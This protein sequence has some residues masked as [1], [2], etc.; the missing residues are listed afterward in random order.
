MYADDILNVKLHHVAVTPA[1]TW[2]FVALHLADQT[3]GWGEA[4]L[5]GTPALLT[6]PLVSARQALVGLRLPDLDAWRQAAPPVD[7]AQAAIAS[8]L[9]QATLDARG[10]QEGRSAAALLGGC[11]RASVPVYANINRRTVNRSPQGFIESAAHAIAAGYTTLKIAPFDGV[12]PATAS[13]PEGRALTEAGLQ[14]IAAT[15]AAA[16]DAV[17]VYVDCHWRFD[18]TAAGVVLDEVAALGVTWFECPLP[19]TRETMVPLRQLRS[20]ANA[21]GVRLAGLESLTHPEAF[22]PWLQA[23]AYDVVMPDVKYAGGI[24]G[25]LRVGELAARHATV[26]AP[27]NP[28]GPLCHAASLIACGVGPHMVQLE[29]QYDETPLF[30]ALVDGGLPPITHGMS[31]LP[32]DPGLG[33]RP[34]AAL[35]NQLATLPEAA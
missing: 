28:T 1:T 6:A 17:Q 31:A 26:C 25:V 21:L 7:M 18:E 10:Q 16:G 11:V 2:S 13:S 24:S 33:V 20:R 8:A 15:K 34:F 35:M 9:E 22:M 19:E 29:H 23:G 14:R 32:E 3:V 12:T 5:V 4:T 30:S 27:H